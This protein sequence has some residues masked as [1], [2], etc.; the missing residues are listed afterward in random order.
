MFFSLN[1]PIIWVR[2]VGVVVAVDEF[3]GRRVYTIDDSTGECIECSVEIPKPPKPGDRS[4]K[5]G[6][7][8]AVSEEAAQSSTASALPAAGLDVGDVVDVK[9]RMG[10][11]RDRKQ[12]RIQKMQPVASTAEEVQFWDKIRDFRREVLS[13]PWILDEREVRRAKK[14]HLADVDEEA[15]RNRRK[16]RHDLR[17]RDEVQ[18]RH[19]E[20]EN[21][22]QTTEL[23]HRPS[24]TKLK[25]EKPRAECQYDAL[26][27]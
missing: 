3:Y 9:G 6:S 2:I 22:H 5:E 25:R 7:R 27:L 20:K 8:K 15:R 11:F 19:D 16:E 14:Q 26:G 1:H 21:R 12:L 23:V 13:Q 10:L 18:R 4:A 24:L 17:R